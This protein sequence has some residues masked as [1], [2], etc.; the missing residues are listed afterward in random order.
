MQGGRI[1]AVDGKVSQLQ[2]AEFGREQLVGS[3]WG[4]GC[5][6]HNS[7][8]ESSTGQQSR[9]EVPER[10]RDRTRH[11]IAI[12]S[13]AMAVLGLGGHNDDK[14]LMMSRS[15]GMFCIII[16]IVTSTNPEPGASP[17]VGAAHTI[18]MLRVGDRVK[19]TP[20]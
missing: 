1:F 7:T 15:H 16:R 19:S 9:I 3:P 4:K 8:F 12:E 6:W 2:P 10:L 17:A 5:W 13:S 18:E 20:S 14:C 11:I